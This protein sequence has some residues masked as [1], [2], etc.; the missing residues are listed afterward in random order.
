MKR[1]LLLLFVL[2]FADK[3][4]S[5][6]FSL[7]SSALSQDS[8]LERLGL[9]FYS[10]RDFL[11]IEKIKEAAKKLIQD[12]PSLGSRRS[13]SKSVELGFS[14]KV[15]ISD[16][17]RMIRSEYLAGEDLGEDRKTIF[18]AL[19]LILSKFQDDVRKKAG[20]V[21]E[22]TFDNW[23]WANIVIRRYNN[24][25]SIGFHTDDLNKNGDTIWTLI[26]ENSV[27]DHGLKFILSEGRKVSVVESPG[28][29]GLGVC[30][31]ASQPG[32]RDC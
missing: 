28:F 18:E 29:P 17:Q 19:A 16:N 10:S 13:I 27:P 2:S 14:N 30:G 3:I 6:S 32:R 25:Q 24:S 9:V 11:N 1:L 7:S 12:S 8:E 21:Q 31:V 22:Q 20:L 5:A 15:T 4:F 23:N 26:L